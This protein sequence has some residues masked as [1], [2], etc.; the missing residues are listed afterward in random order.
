MDQVPHISRVATGSTQP[1]E[2]KMTTLL[3]SPLYLDGVDGSGSSRIDRTKRWIDWYKALRS[4]NGF[5]FDDMLLLDNASNASQ[6]LDEFHGCKLIRFSQFLDRGGVFDYPYCWRAIYWI[7]N[8]ILFGKYDRIMLIDTDAFIVSKRLLAYVNS[9]ESGWV[10]FWC[11]TNGFPEAA[12]HVLCKD[13][14]NFYLDF[15][16]GDFMEHN[17]KCMET[18]LPFTD[19][20]R[21]FNCG[22]WGELGQYQAP[23]MDL[24]CQASVNEPLQFDIRI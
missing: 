23:G 4:D 24:Y 11:Q 17:G 14:F 19:V 22:R 5:H 18:L 1:L 16:K 10:T 7:R 20:E 9:I 2:T 6:G 3:Y 21:R 12:F 15:T 13:M 8:M